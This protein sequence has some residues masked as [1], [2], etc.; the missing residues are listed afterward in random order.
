MIVIVFI[1][2]LTS[3]YFAVRY[4]LLHKNIKNMTNE[5]I[6]VVD[7]YGAN[8]NL[9][10][11]SPNKTFE[12]YLIVLNQFIERTGEERIE[13]EKR[14]KNIRREISYISHDLRTPLTSILGYLELVKS[15]DI[16]DEE[17]REYLQIITKRSKNLQ[18]LIEQFYD[19]SRINDNSYGIKMDSIDLHRQLCDHILLYYNDFENKGINIELVMEDKPL[20]VKGDD[21]AIGRIINNLIE[22]A[23]KYTKDTL[24]IRLKKGNGKAAITFKNLAYPLTEK[25]VQHLFD[26]FYMKDL[27]RNSNSSGLGLTIAKMLAEGM[28]GSMDAQI[29]GEW[30]EIKVIFLM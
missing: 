9:H 28:G 2:L 23:I 10:I 17:K 29:V 8:R 1:L 5:L 15:T 12:E 26:R 24:I 6:D 14:E 13:H 25:E 4:F 7:T 20:F 30:L 11:H 3:V 19:Y 21:N 22:N 18:S 27:A 16:S